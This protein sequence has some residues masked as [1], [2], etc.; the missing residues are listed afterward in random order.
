MAYASGKNT[1]QAAGAPI[2]PAIPKAR[3][4]NESNTQFLAGRRIA[5]AS[6]LWDAGLEPLLCV[7]VL[8]EQHG[9][10]RFTTQINK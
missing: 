10:I 6:K 3:H 2:L 1:L 8:E 7:T 4:A 9:F 5:G